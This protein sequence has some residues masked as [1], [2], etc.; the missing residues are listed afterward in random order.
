VGC[1]ARRTT[2]QG[3]TG[4]SVE[5]RQ[6]PR[7]LPWEPHVSRGR[8]CE[9]ERTNLGLVD[10]QVRAVGPLETLFIEEGQVVLCRQVLGLKQS[11]SR[12]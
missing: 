8:R 5:T 9:S 4:D 6:V 11:A 12:V 1:G 3:G 2:A 7:Q 10:R